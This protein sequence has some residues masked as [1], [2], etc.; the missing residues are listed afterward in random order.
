MSSSQGRFIG[1]QLRGRWGRKAVAAEVIN[2]ELWGGVGGAVAADIVRQARSW[3]A[4][5]PAGSLLRRLLGAAKGAGNLL[6]AVGGVGEAHGAAR[7]VGK[8][9]RVARPAAGNVVAA[10]HTGKACACPVG[11][12]SGCM[13][14]RF[15]PQSQSP[16][17]S[18]ALCSAATAKP[19]AVHLHVQKG[20]FMPCHS[21]LKD[22]QAAA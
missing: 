16:L 12:R 18:A 4:F 17:C 22:P 2:Q 21:P 7:V 20:L 10:G 14:F 5:A 6:G 15:V 11:W 1:E 19:C 3:G 8:G 9:I 13:P